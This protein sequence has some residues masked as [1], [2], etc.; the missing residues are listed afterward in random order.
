MAAHSVQKIDI[1][2]LRARALELWPKVYGFG[3]SL[4][5]DGSRAEDLC[6]EAYLHLFS[7]KRKVDPSRPLLPL[8]IAIVRNLWR[9]EA[10]RPQ[11]K[12][13][14]VASEATEAVADPIGSDPARRAARHEAQREVQSVLERLSPLGHSVLYLRDG[15]G[16]SYKEI[17]GLVEKSED[18]VRVT[19]HRARLKARE[20]LKG[21]A[22]NE[23][24]AQ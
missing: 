4:T 22:Q 15:L 14:D 5:R 21:F 23:G 10:R 16:F 12:P 1:E 24:R 13:L 17:A 6:Q 7:M 9:S 11:A 2:S 20:L 3:I 18:T 19:L 8:L